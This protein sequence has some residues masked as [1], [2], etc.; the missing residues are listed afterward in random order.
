MAN[1]LSQDFQDFIIALNKCE[2][3]YVLV[4]GYAV[5]YHGYNR[6][7]GDLDIYVE[8]SRSNYDCLSKAFK[9]FG[10][11]LFD[12][13]EKNFMDDQLYEVFTFGSPPVSID[14]I[15]SLKGVSFNEAKQLSKIGIIDNIGSSTS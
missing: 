9:N 14:I 6:T 5:I 4:G 10:L 15:T 1:I 13:T 7:T 11:S 12:M 3:N 2:V 8:R